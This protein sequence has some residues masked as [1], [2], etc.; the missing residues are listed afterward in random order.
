MQE[1]INPSKPQSTPSHNSAK[2]RVVLVH[3]RRRCEQISDSYLPCNLLA[4]GFYPFRW[5]GVSIIIPLQEIENYCPW[6]NSTQSAIIWS[7]SATC[8]SSPIQ[9]NIRKRKS[10]QKWEVKWSWSS[11]KY[12]CRHVP[13]VVVPW[14]EI[15]NF[16]SSSLCHLFV[17]FYIEFSE[18]ILSKCSLFCAV[19]FV[20]WW[21]PVIHRPHSMRSVSRVS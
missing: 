2:K 3:H 15:I 16:T 20:F 1:L 4:Y 19:L 14:R 9:L 5:N 12:N 7:K 21:P 6:V 17:L 8:K 18:D 11:F 10:V 13:V